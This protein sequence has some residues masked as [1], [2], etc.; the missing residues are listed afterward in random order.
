MPICWKNNQRLAQKLFSQ[1]KLLS[2]RK[3][4]ES[5]MHIKLIFN[6]SAHS[7]EAYDRLLEIISSYIPVNINFAT[8]EGNKLNNVEMG[9]KQIS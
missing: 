6:N 2:K 5:I 7:D 9:E 8:L 4:G 3:D 1:N